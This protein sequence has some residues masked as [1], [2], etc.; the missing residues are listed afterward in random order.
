MSCTGFP[1]E[2]DSAFNNRRMTLS[3]AQS[4][5]GLPHAELRNTGRRNYVPY[6]PMDSATRARLVEYFRPHNADLYDLLG[7]RFDWDR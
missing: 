5:L 2:S 7:Q 1:G 3:R 6:P 4:F